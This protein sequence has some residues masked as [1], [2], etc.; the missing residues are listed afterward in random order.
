MLLPDNFQE[1]VD[2]HHL[3][4]LELDEM[5]LSRRP[6]EIFGAENEQEWQAWCEFFGRTREPGKR[7]GLVEIVL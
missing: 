1:L 2:A 4:A 3:A 7:K 5:F 6:E